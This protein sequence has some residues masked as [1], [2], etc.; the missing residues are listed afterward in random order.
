MSVSLKV[1]IFESS[2]TRT[3]QVAKSSLTIGSAVHCDLV[4][5]H[6]TVNGE[7]VRV[8]LD[9][10]R[11]WV[12]DL[13]SPG[14]TSLNEIRLPSLKPM[15]MR[16]L[17]ILRLGQSESTLG[18]EALLV[19][20][21][22]VKAQP[23]IA[24][25]EPASTRPEPSVTENKKEVRDSE[26]TQRREDLRTLSRDL[27]EVRLQLQMHRL[28]RNAADEMNQQLQNLRDETKAV[29]TQKVKWT[30]TL[31]QL[32][33]DKAQARKDAAKELSEHK[34]RLENDFKTQQELEQRKLAQAKRQSVTDLLKA[35]QVVVNQKAVAW[36]GRAFSSEMVV[37]WESDLDA[38][39]RSV[40]L[41]EAQ[42]EG[43]KS[44]PVPT[45][46][47]ATP[48]AGATL[49]IAAAN[50]AA[51]GM[52]Q[53]SSKIK[54][55][56]SALDAP[57]AVMNHLVGRDTPWKSVGMA[58][59]GVLTIIFGCWLALSYYKQRGNRSFSSSNSSRS[60]MRGK[61]AARF[62]PKQNRKYRNTYTE[63]V[64]YLENYLA[65]EQ[66]RDFH[67]LW[68]TELSRVGAG[69]WKL[70]PGAANAVLARELSLLNELGTIR[71][72]LTVD[73]E[74]EGTIQMR[75]RE[76][77]YLHD[78]EAMLKSRAAVDRFLKFKRAFYVRNQ[79]YLS[80]GVG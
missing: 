41:G 10:G 72:G 80:P 44:A 35:T 25:P 53:Q 56:R 29:E 3:L 18:I 57:I 8:W 34:L 15:L 73:R 38:I 43:V 14:G 70:A 36:A 32:E 50:A 21:P 30:D 64:L 49:P 39:F 9:G 60:E 69:E 45:P 63:N 1:K 55:K 31:K 37:E 33:V 19:R 27:A 12:Q 46:T 79:V 75:A 52:A 7:H 16:D 68:Q 42:T 54:I 6:P 59:I 67:K 11:I 65:A 48:I 26:V 20:A 77:E 76:A 24:A 17:D 51:N 71:D 13:G 62:L 4:I 40:L 28:E 61:V 23:Q 2:G 22:M 5:D 58:S 74:Q 66:N 47:A 78:L